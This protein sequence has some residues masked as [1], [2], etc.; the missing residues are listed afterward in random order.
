MRLAI[1]TVIAAVVLAFGLPR[2]AVASP[3]GY[4][5]YEIGDIAAPTPG[6]VEGGMMLMGGGD[7]PVSAFRWFANKA[8]NGHIVV[9]RASGAEDAGEEIYRDIGN[10][11]SVRTIVFDD[12]KASSDPRVLALLAE[13]DGIFLAGGDQ[14][15][16][17]RFWKGTPVEDALNNHVAQGRPIG[18]TSAGLAVL[19]GAAYGAMDDGSVNSL[20]ALKDPLGP[21][22][23]MVTDFLTMPYLQHVVTDTHFAARDRLGRLI[24]FVANV[25][26]T[27]DPEAIGLGVDEEGALC[28][29]ADGTARYHGKGYAWLVQ[30]Q[31]M[32]QATVGQPLNFEDVR[33]TTLG[34]VGTIDLKTM[35]I[36]L[37]AFSGVAA[38]REG[39]LVNAPVEPVDPAAVAR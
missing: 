27:S 8:G 37:P 26:A 17:V 29:E 18:G 24:A 11:T 32:P 23:T 2:A 10:V 15:K 34:T 12:R 38:V 39:L 19:G 1:F 7:W 30:P 16:Y 35:T 14:A 22:V 25:R 3:D 13:A 31:G 4:A 20:S 6:K 21:E 28:V 33:V 9:L 5:Y 36:D